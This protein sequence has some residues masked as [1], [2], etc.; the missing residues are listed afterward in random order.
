M[1]HYVYHYR[2]RESTIPGIFQEK[3]NKP[4]LPTHRPSFW[5]E[6]PKDDFYNTII[7]LAAHYDVMVKSD[8]TT[9]GSSKLFIF[10]DDKG[11][12]FKQC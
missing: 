7:E 12:G 3:T 8:K 2:G 6:I 5:L 9:N 1:K 11:K 4:V 10:L